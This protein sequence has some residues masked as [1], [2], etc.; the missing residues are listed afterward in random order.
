M[1]S[2]WRFDF[3]VAGSS[4]APPAPSAL[5][6][7][8]VRDAAPADEAALVALGVSTGLFSPDEADALLR[9]TLREHF[10][11]TASAAPASAPRAHARVVDGA[12]GAPAGWA[13]L[14][15]ESGGGSRG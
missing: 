11:D 4:I 5:A 8:P 3:S 7:F 1:S 6:P 12:D 9:D 15:A 14:R 2:I 13:F 10:V